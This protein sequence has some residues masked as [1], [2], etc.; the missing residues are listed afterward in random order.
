MSI[1]ALASRNQ[2]PGW[3]LMNQIN[4]QEAGWAASFKKIKLNEF[5]KVSTKGLICNIFI[6]TKIMIWHCMDVIYIHMY[7]NN[8]QEVGRVASFKKIEHNDFLIK[9]LIYNI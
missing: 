6:F 4:I 1:I 7:P 9:S 8:T 5:W 3:A 2:W